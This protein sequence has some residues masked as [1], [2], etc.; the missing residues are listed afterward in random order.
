MSNRKKY[1]IFSYEAVYRRMGGDYGV[2]TRMERNVE[3]YNTLLAF[4][5]K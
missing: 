5:S 2:L 4:F 3:F 1:D